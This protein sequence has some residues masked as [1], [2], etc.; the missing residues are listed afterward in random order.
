MV[1]SPQVV[2]GCGCGPWAPYFISY[3]FIYQH[4]PTGHHLRLLSQQKP[5]EETCWRMLVILHIPSWMWVKNTPCV[6]LPTENEPNRLPCPSTSHRWSLGGHP[7]CPFGA[8]TAGTSGGSGGGSN[9]TGHLRIWRSPAMV[10]RQSPL[11]SVQRH[12][13]T[14]KAPRETTGATV[15][16]RSAA[17]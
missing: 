5:P 8:P 12:A 7:I 2:S 17:P 16:T 6:F 4:P 1:L 11:R 15:A 14:R 3:I 9:T 10:T 13:L